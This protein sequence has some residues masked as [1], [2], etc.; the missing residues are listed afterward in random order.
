MKRFVLLWLALSGIHPTANA[1]SAQT[2]SDVYLTH[3]F[4]QGEK[5]STVFS[6]TVSTTSNDLPPMVYR[7]GG[8]GDYTV[9]G[10]NA[11]QPEFAA[12]FL[13]DGRPEDKCSIAFRDSGKTLVYNGRPNTNTDAS[14]L[15]YNPLLWG[16]PPAK[17]GK[18]MSWEVNITQPWEL[19]GAGKQH[20]QVL[21][22]DP[23][24]KIIRLK[25]EGDGEGFFADDQQAIE[26]VKDGKKMRAKVIPGK[27]HWT[28]YTIFKNG[29]VLSDELMVE[30]PV[31]LETDNLRIAATQRQYIMLNLR[32]Q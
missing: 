19:G 18:G 21:D 15:A 4:V 26:M 11:L 22:A 23:T 30:R 25:R 7:V 10:S 29:I 20:V 9:T 27:H 16:I 3:Q 6:R 32:P 24:A 8:T 13:Y 14:G 5:F 17:L 1:Q 31:I 28:G 12:V 2:F